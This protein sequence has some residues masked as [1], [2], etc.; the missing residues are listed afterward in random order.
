MTAGDR[1]IDFVLS[2][3]GGYSCHES[4]P[5]G[6]TNFG[7]SKRSYPNED[8]KNL[9]RERAKEIYHEDYW[10]SV[11]GPD[12]PEQ[13][14]VPLMDY[15]VNSGVWQAIRA[16]Q[17][18]L[19][20]KRDGRFGVLTMTAVRQAVA[21]KGALKLAEDLILERALFLVKIGCRRR[22]SEVFLTGWMRRIRDNLRY[23][24]SYKE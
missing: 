6:E 18:T 23:V 4:D 1:A 3:E 14:A 15:A 20:V 19:R 5:G 21:E 16:L 8:I 22:G 17:A 10:L 11:R 9:S 2:H 13:L 24:R 7:I 12:L